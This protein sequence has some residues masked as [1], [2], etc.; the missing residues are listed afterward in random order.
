MEKDIV[1][2]PDGN[3]EAVTYFNVGR[4]LFGAG[5]FTAEIGV[6]GSSYLYN[7]MENGGALVPIGKAKERSNFYLR[8]LKEPDPAVA[9]LMARTSQV[10]V[11][12]LLYVMILTSRP[13]TFPPLDYH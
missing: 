12:Y 11:S 3:A 9:Y 2:K 6:D 10:H 4:I 8:Q 13:K 5:H 7:D 1:I